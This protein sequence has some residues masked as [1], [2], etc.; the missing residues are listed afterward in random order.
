M[1]GKKDRGEGGL[2]QRDCKAP[3][4][5]GGRYKTTENGLELI[6]AAVGRLA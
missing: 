5:K 2:C 1:R 3:A 4:S 6:V